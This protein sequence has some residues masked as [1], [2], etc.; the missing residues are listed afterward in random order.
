LVNNSGILK[1][2]LCGA[3]WGEYVKTSTY[4]YLVFLCIYK[5]PRSVFL[6]GV[7]PVGVAL[8]D[9]LS[10]CTVIYYCHWLLM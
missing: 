9:S 4:F 5:L 2:H 10:L 7:Y 6:V 3:L 1:H 8:R